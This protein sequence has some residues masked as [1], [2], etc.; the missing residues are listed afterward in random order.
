M[1]V[2]DVERRWPRPRDSWARQNAQPCVSLS[3]PGWNGSS[4]VEPALDDLR[5]HDQR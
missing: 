2:V 5:M 4:C 1:L 3:L